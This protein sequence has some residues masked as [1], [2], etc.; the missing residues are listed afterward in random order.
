MAVTRVEFVT[1]YKVCVIWADE[2]YQP[3]ARALGEDNPEL[4]QAIWM[5]IVKLAYL[6]EFQASGERSLT[7]RRKPEVGVVA[8][9]SFAAGKLVVVPVSRSCILQII[10]N[11]S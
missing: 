9:K 11:V 3:D 7:V 10:S 5:G 4:M 6:K 1:T 2:E 8:T